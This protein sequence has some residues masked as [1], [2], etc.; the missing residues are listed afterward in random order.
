MYA[1]DNVVTLQLEL[2][3]LFSAQSTSAAHLVWG[4]ENGC[5]GILSFSQPNKSL[6]L[7]PLITFNVCEIEAVLHVAIHHTCINP[8]CCL[9]AC[10]HIN[11]NT[12][13]D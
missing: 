2:S 12:A 10:M 4:D 8:N 1:P 7:S 3:P 13:S 6:F 5:V 11:F 9:L